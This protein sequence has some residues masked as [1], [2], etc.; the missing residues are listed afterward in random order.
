MSWW[1]RSAQH[2]CDCRLSDPSLQHDGLLQISLLTFLP[3]LSETIAKFS[4]VSTLI[5]QSSIPDMI[6]PLK[7]EVISILVLLFTHT[8]LNSRMTFSDVVAVTE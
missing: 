1:L 5:G 4:N 3:Q 6:R 8:A 2:A 7:L